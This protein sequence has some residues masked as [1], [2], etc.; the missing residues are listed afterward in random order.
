MTFGNFL[1]RAAGGAGRL[2]GHVGSA[3][4]TVGEVGG[5]VVKGFAESGAAPILKTAVSL[6]GGLLTPETGGASAGIAAGIN[7]GIDFITSKGQGI[8]SKISTVGNIA[9][10]VGGAL[11]QAAMK[12]M[13]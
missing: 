12:G 5:N 7:K 8:A 13:G 11:S 3:L 10:G 4:R 6:A 2:I 9:S 1:R